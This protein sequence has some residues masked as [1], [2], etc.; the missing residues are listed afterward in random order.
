MRVLEPVTAR[1]AWAVTGAAVVAVVLY[2]P[3]APRSPVVYRELA[4]STTRGNETAA[5]SA[6]TRTRLRLKLNTRKL[7]PAL[8][9]YRSVVADSK[10]H[11]VYE[12]SVSVTEPNV[13]SLPVPVA[14]NS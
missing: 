4:L 5:T 13:V 6:T 14:L 8:S 10:G 7:L 9:S 12:S 2:F 1:P 3:F 11:P